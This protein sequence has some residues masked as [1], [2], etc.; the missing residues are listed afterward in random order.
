[1]MGIKYAYVVIP[2]IMFAPIYFVLIPSAMTELLF[3]FIVV[4]SVFLF[5][6]GDYSFSAIVISFLP[7]A[8]N[9]G[10]VI[11]PLFIIG[12]LLKKQYKVL[13]FLLTAFSFLSIFG[14]KYFGSIFWI[15]KNNPYTGATQIYGSGKLLY[16]VEKSPEIFGIPLIILFLLGIF[17]ATKKLID[18]KFRLTQG[19]YFYLLV[20]GSLAIYFS[21][22]SYVWWKGIGGSLGLTRVMAGI[23]PLI[24][25]VAAYSLDYIPG[26]GQIKKFASVVAI[27]FI[28]F[29]P[30][31]RYKVPFEIDSL[32]KLIKESSLWM[33]NEGLDKKLIFYYDPIFCHYL[34]LDPFDH[35]KAREQIWNKE[36]P[37]EAVPVGALV[38]WDAHFGPNE[39][40]MPVERLLSN[41]AFKVIRHVEPEQEVRVLNGYKYEIYIFERI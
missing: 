32:E 16:F 39:G 21:A 10:I 17:Y 37:E 26:K 23:V 20:I 13:P 36:K 40:H 18:E 12:F 19:F 3:G 25:L 29:I 22:H 38:I 1:L 15:L 41:P 33:K 5:F 35:E 7:F 31:S 27:L 11:L 34:K 2:A 30:F 28:L 24:A 8:R 9:E 6:K 4:F 14:W